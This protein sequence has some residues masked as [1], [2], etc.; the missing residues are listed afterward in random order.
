MGTAA[1]AVVSHLSPARSAALCL[2]FTRLGLG[3]AALLWFLPPGS[4]QRY[5]DRVRRRGGIPAVQAFREGTPEWRIRRTLRIVA[6]GCL[7]MAVVAGVLG[8]LYLTRTLRPPV[9][10]SSSRR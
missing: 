4:Y 6:S 7:V 1:A 2:T 5:R 10:T 9:A 8:L 3:G